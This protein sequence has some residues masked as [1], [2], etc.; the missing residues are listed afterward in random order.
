M[1]AGA[2]GAGTAA[3]QDTL[4]DSTVGNSTRV[5]VELSYCPVLQL[6]C[7]PSCLHQLRAHLSQHSSSC[8]C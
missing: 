5:H 8:G 4:P 6:V 1:L 3:L 7:M 2:A